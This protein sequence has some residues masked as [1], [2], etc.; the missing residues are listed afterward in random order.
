[1][2]HAPGT[3][4]WTDLAAPDMPAATAFYTG[5]FGWTSE[6]AGGDSEDTRGYTFFR[7][8][9]RLV[10][11]YGPPGPGEPPSWRPYVAVESADD[12]AA[13]VREAGG[14]VMLDPMDVMDQGRTTVFVDPAGAVCC[15]WQPKAHEGAEVTSE[16]GGLGWLEHTTRDREGAKRFYGAVF[17]WEVK[18]VDEGYEIWTLDGTEVAGLT[19][20]EH[21][22]P[23][24]PPHWLV[25]FTV[26]D[27]DAVTT[28]AGELGGGVRVPPTTVSPP[29]RDDIRFAVLADPNGAP[30]GV[31]AG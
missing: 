2:A 7:L 31:F 6:P 17:G 19:T 29:D 27:V 3:F 1:M 20:M 23:E 8:D 25:N 14:Q 24:M 12:T 26:E 18:D 22:P 13:R 15:A 4:C 5:L 21:H 11:G 9:G 16:P 30:F 28:R 10:A